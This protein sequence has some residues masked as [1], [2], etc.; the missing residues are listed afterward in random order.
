[1]LLLLGCG[2]DPGGSAQMIQNVLTDFN[3]DAGFVRL[4]D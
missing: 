1:M 3:M 2:G 4:S